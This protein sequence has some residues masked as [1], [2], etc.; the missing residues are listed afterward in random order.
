MVPRRRQVVGLKLS[1]ETEAVLLSSIKR[2]GL[3]ELEQNFG[4][5][6][7]RSVLEFCLQEIGPSIYNQAIA[8][9]QQFFA[10]KV[11]DLPG[12]RQEKEFGY[13]SK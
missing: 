1:K 10:E 3:E 2:F 4:E 13:W 11:E 7:A 6:K 9:A 5:I 12:A 8:D